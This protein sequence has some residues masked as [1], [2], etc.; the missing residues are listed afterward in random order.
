MTETVFT[1]W[2]V[3]NEILNIYPDITYMQ[4][5]PSQCED[6]SFIL[7]LCVVIISLP[8]I[9]IVK[10]ILVKLSLSFHKDGII[11]NKE[12]WVIWT[13]QL[14]T[15]YREYLVKTINLNG[16]KAV[17]CRWMPHCWRRQITG[18]CHVQPCPLNCP[19]K[20]TVT[21]NWFNAQ[22]VCPQFRC[23]NSFLPSIL[24]FNCLYYV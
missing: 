6:S 18:D 15:A 13:Q 20:H 14:P 17:G 2:I 21:Q 16:K 23:Y 12:K 4:W 24:L 9:C 22:R 19:W 7:Y 3:C 10:I 11:A 8:N 1:F 5:L